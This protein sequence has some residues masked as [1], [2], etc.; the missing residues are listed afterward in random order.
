MHEGMRSFFQYIMINYQQSRFIE[1]NFQWKYWQHTY[2]CGMTPP[3]ILQAYYHGNTAMGTKGLNRLFF[4]KS[5]NG[6]R[7]LNK[8]IRVVSPPYLCNTCNDDDCDFWLDLSSSHYCKIVLSHFRQQNI[9]FVEKSENL[10]NI[11]EIRPIEPS[12]D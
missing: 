6:Q 8:C 12:A 11:L 10:S 3:E 1:I 5:L 9:I 4:I 2:L 7:H